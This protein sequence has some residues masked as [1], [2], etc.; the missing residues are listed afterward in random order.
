[1]SKHATVIVLTPE[2]QTAL[3]K[4]I[5]RP[6]TEHRFVERARIVAMAAAGTTTAEIAAVLLT[7]PARVSQWRTRFAARR[8]EGLEDLPRPG[9]KR[10]YD[11]H[12]Q[13][14]ILALLRE[15]PPSGY[16]TWSGPLLSAA[17]GDVPVAAVWQMLRAQRISLQR[18]R[19]W[20]ISTDPEFAS[21]AA[22]IVGLYLAPRLMPW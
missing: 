1:M 11:Q 6:R 2:E 10:K 8:L 13:E 9:P 12:T 19:S 15:P 5:H 21:K 17:L 4:L 20:C 3:R 16:A 18:R 22:D 14:R 7:R